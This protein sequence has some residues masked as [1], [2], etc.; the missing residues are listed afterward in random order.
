M[1]TLFACILPLFA[2]CAHLGCGTRPP[3]ANVDSVLVDTEQGSSF[4]G[5][6][7][8]REI[9]APLRREI[10]GSDAPKAQAVFQALNFV[11]EYY[12]LPPIGLDQ[13]HELPTLYCSST[14]EW[15]RDTPSTKYYCAL[16]Y[17]KTQNGEIN[18]LECVDAAPAKVLFTALSE[19]EPAHENLKYGLGIDLKNVTSRVDELHFDDYGNYIF[20][21]QTNVNLQGAA[22]EQF[23][24]VFSLLNID[25]SDGSAFLVCSKD[26]ELIVKCGYQFQE[27]HTQLDAE[28]SIK[29]WNAIN[30]AMLASSFEIPWKGSSD[31]MTIANVSDLSFD[32]SNV[33]MSLFVDNSSPPKPKA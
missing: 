13:E 28:L 29:L 5:L 26:S 10:I 3:D 27:K 23:L 14:Y 18:K 9:V 12:N 7:P 8:L 31:E 2:L 17:R 25:N 30:L 11:F 21:A 1:K 24:Q 33:R 22:A 4:H 6:Y 16:Q 20:P 32:G 15:W 19:V